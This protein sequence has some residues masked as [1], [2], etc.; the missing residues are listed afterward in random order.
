[1]GFYLPIYH[2]V[3]WI[4]GLR[5]V[6]KISW[7]AS[8]LSIPNFSAPHDERGLRV[9]LSGKCLKRMAKLKLKRLTEWLLEVEM[10]F[11]W[12]T[13]GLAII[14]FV[15]AAIWYIDPALLTLILRFRQARCVTRNH[16]FLIGISNCSWTS[17]RLGCTREVYKCWQIQVRFRD[18]FFYI[19]LRNKKPAYSF[20]TCLPCSG[21]HSV[22]IQAAMKQKRLKDFYV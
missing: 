19:N 22:Q 14:I 5:F 3:P 20:K 13:A 1:M 4:S 11:V 10:G 6:W 18:F 15:F 7:L 12:A 21:R 16:A 9:R 8:I 2:C 17:C